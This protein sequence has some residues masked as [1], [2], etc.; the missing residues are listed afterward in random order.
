M[1]FQMKK[2]FKFLFL[3]VNFGKVLCSSANKLQQNSKW[4]F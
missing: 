3:L 4:F 1:E 2:L